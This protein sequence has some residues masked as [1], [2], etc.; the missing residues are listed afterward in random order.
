MTLTSRC[1]PRSRTAYTLPATRLDTNSVPLSPQVM[2][3]ALLIPWAHS[4]ALKPG[5]TLSFWI[6]ISPGAAGA[7]GWAIGAS[8]ESAIDD[9]WPCFQ[10][11]GA[12][13]EAIGASAS[14]RSDITAKEV[15]VR[16]V[17]VEPPR[18]GPVRGDDRRPGRAGRRS[19]VDDMSDAETLSRRGAAGARGRPRARI[20]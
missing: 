14:P 8:V 1:P 18:R 13:P 4:S 20:G 11:G 15:S 6:G 10:G 12:C 5:G 17:M 2:A 16:G 7:G 19:A 3:R 9:G